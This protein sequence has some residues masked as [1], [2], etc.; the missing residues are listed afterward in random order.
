MED[1]VYFLQERVCPDYAEQDVCNQGVEQWWPQVS[2]LIFNDEAAKY[3]C[4]G[5]NNECSV[6]KV[7]DC[8]TCLADLKALAQFYLNEDVIEAHVE[9]LN[10]EVFCMGMELDEEFVAYCQAIVADFLPRAIRALF[11]DLEQGPNEAGCNLLY[12][13]ICKNSQKFWITK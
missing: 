4:A 5:L 13:G 10:G 11:R 2:Q 8:E 7:W 3:T 12:D 1:V 9:Y 6:E